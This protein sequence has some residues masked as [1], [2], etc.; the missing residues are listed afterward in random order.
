MESMARLSGLRPLKS[1][2][3]R[4]LACIAYTSNPLICSPANFRC[5]SLSSPRFAD[6]EVGQEALKTSE[7][8]FSSRDL[9]GAPMTDE[10]FKVT[11]TGFG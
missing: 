4:I 10:G 7:I 1:T 8:T 2:V 9:K 11:E 5:E 6:V 3:L